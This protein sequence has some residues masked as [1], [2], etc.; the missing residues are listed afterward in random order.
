MAAAGLVVRLDLAL[1]FPQISC[2][3]AIKSR[4]TNG[5]TFDGQINDTIRRCV[6][7]GNS[8]CRRPPVCYLPPHSNFQSI[9]RSELGP[10]AAFGAIVDAVELQLRLDDGW[11]PRHLQFHAEVKRAT[12][13]AGRPSGRVYCAGRRNHHSRRL[14]SALHHLRHWYVA[15]LQRYTRICSSCSN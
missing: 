2:C 6:G 7:R 13:V 4:R 10:G 5:M 3:L 14:L 15:K 1:K 12:L 8:F 9:C 11:R